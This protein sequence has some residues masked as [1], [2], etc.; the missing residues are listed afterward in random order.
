M[1][2]TYPPLGLQ[3]KQENG[4]SCYV[5]GEKLIFEPF[6]NDYLFLDKSKAFK[7]D[8]FNLSSNLITSI[9]GFLICYLDSSDVNTLFNFSHMEDGKEIKSKHGEFLEQWEQFN[10]KAVINVAEIPY[11]KNLCKEIEGFWWAI[12]KKLTVPTKESSLE[13]KTLEVIKLQ[14]ESSTT[15]SKAQYRELKLS[16]KVN[17][18][19][20]VT[21]DYLQDVE[22]IKLESD[23]EGVFYFDSTKDVEVINAFPKV[24]LPFAKPNVQTYGKKGYSSTSEKDK[25]LSRLEGLETLVTDEGLKRLVAVKDKLTTFNQGLDVPTVTL[26]DVINL[27][28]K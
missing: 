22:W 3:L 9:D 8:I 21:S 18:L 17:V 1:A 13:E 28:V 15:L 23:Q 27:I 24:N 26:M 6:Q 5:K 7:E 11:L 4:K 25:I 20:L 2:I 16:A 12:D 19:N 14:K 10:W